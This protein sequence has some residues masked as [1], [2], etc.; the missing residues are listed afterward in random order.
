MSAPTSLARLPVIV[1]RLPGGGLR[2]SSPDLPGWSRVGRGAH[3][4]ARNLD[5]AW[6]ELQVAA[7]AAGHGET[8]DLAHHDARPETQ[9]AVRPLTRPDG[10]RIWRYSHDP[11]EWRPLPS[12][13]WE[14][15]SGRTY[16]GDSAAVAKVIARRTQLGLPVKAPDE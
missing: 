12:G 6:L 7:Y 2:L 8:Y 13:D 14:S 4:L 10:A 15:P 9:P 1:E 5:E 16:R 3:E 11:A